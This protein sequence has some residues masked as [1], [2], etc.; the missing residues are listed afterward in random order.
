MFVRR[1]WRAGVRSCSVEYEG[2]EVHGDEAVKAH[3]G[4]LTSFEGENHVPDGGCVEGSESSA[5]SP[6]RPVQ[7]GH[8]DDVW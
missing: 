7:H 4:R 3:D 6:W 8:C 2:G 5:K 1:F